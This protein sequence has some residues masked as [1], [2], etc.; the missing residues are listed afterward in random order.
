MSSS[1]EVY[2]SGAMIDGCKEG[3]MHP[4]SGGGTKY[5][6]KASQCI[7]HRSGIDLCNRLPT[8]LVTN[9]SRKKQWGEDFADC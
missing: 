9:C 1:G 8:W 6:M 4:A 2:R 3:E 7:G 5:I